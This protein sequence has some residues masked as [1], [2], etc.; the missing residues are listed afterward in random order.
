VAQQEWLIQVVV[1]AT[2]DE[3]DAITERIAKVICIPADHDG[4]CTTPWVTMTSAVEDED[5]P[6]PSELLGLLDE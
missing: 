6:R 4:P 3:A 1:R 5:E 2:R